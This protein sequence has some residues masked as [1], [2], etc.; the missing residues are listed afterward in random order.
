ME[1]AHQSKADSGDRLH[2]SVMRRE[3]NDNYT[4]QKGLTH[5]GKN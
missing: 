1:N 3:M 4:G 2:T 5:E